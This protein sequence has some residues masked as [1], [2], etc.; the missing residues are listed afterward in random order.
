M[1]AF[2]N[3]IARVSG[4]S[5][6]M[7]RATHPK[8]QETRDIPVPMRDGV[9]LLTDLYQPVSETLLP[10]F[11]TRTPYDRRAI[12]GL[13][14]RTLAERG[15]Q[16]VSQSCRGTFGSGGEFLPFQTDK[17]DGVD[18]LKWIAQQPW[19]NGQVVMA[20]LS[21]PGCAALALAADAPEGMLSC[22]VIQHAASHVYDVFRP[23]GTVGLANLLNWVYLESIRALPTMQV[24]IGFAKRRRTMAK[25][26]AHLPV[27][28]LDTVAIGSPY[29]FFQHV[30]QSP[31]PESPLWAATNHAATIEQVNTPIHLISGWSDFFLDPLLDDYHH[32]LKAGKKPTLTIGDWPHAPTLDSLKAINTVT[33][34]WLRAETSAHEAVV[35][36][37]PVRVQLVGTKQWRAC[38][39]WPP[40]TQTKHLYLTVY[41][42]L[43]VSPPAQS[44]SSSRYT[45]DPANPTPSVGGALLYDSIGHVDNTQLESRADVLTFTTEPLKQPLEVCGEPSVRLFVRTSAR[46]TDFFVRLCDVTPDGKSINITDGIVRY[47]ACNYETLSYGM[48]TMDVNMSATACRFEVGHRIRLQVSSGAHPRYGRNLGVDNPSAQ[49]SDACVA[50]QEVFHESEHSSMVSLPI[51]L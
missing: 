42:S 51:L 41:H 35:R 32:L 21:Y 14:E 18:T 31:N 8:V 24:Y 6:G 15:F 4:R 9:A 49:L 38:D 46:T 30:L 40:S 1:G 17:E 10:V 34:S 13:L 43:S 22:L 37:K 3:L 27:T 48:L 36:S 26:L 7:G 39:E 45:Y 16:V 20:G 50:S 28:E 12:G 29:T 2:N 44:E 33:L 19:Y 25:A 11:L 47:P 23:R 5:F